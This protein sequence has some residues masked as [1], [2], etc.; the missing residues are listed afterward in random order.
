[1][2][3][4]GWMSIIHNAFFGKQFRPFDQK[5]R[6]KCNKYGGR[7]I[8]CGQQDANGHGPKTPNVL[9]TRRDPHLKAGNQSTFFS[10]KDMKGTGPEHFC[11]A[12]SICTL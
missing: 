2:D 1:M 4:M 11:Q 12:L 7:V 9:A 10:A 8:F 6:T 3:G 5:K